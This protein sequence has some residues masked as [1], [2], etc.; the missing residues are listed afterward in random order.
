MPTE[1]SGIT[2]EIVVEL[3]AEP[4]V[5]EGQGPAEDRLSGHKAEVEGF[6]ETGDAESTYFVGENEDGPVFQTDKGVKGPAEDRLASHDAETK[7]FEARA[8]ES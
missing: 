8:S 6:V 5:P 2:D 1:K 7:A 4:T 3:N